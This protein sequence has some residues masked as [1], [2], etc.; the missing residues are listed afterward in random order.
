MDVANA[1]QF[2]IDNSQSNFKT[3]GT[4]MKQFVDL[5]NMK[6]QHHNMLMNY[7]NEIG[8]SAAPLGIKERKDWFIF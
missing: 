3:M 1:L 5:T 7:L 8:D 4:A 2:S 6:V